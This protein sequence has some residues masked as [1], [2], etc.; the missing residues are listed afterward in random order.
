[1][2]LIYTHD[3]YYAKECNFDHMSENEIKNACIRLRYCQKL[4]A[5]ENAFKI[6]QSEE[7]IEEMKKIMDDAYKAYSDLL[8]KR[9]QQLTQQVN[10]NAVRDAR[11]QDKSVS[12]SWL[13]RTLANPANWG[14]TRTKI[15]KTLD[16][17]H[18]EGRDAALKYAQSKGLITL[19]DGT[20][21][22]VHPKLRYL[23]NL[24]NTQDKV[25]ASKTS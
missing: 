23:C 12:G 7:Q 14:K 17:L 18:D 5:E 21:D 24:L 20:Y 13:D 16:L 15:A 22:S 3:F 2:L 10:E 25:Y 6:S 4:N 8:A 9:T 11:V 1:M 19:K